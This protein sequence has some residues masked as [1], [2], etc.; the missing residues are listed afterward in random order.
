VEVELEES[1]AGPART[2]R[3]EGR[4]LDACDEAGAPVCFSCR[5]GDCGTCRVEVLAG[6]DR[7]SPPSADEAET[8]RRLGAA[9][10]DRLACQV[11]VRR[12]PGL[13]RLRWRGT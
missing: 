1:A 4:L 5:G 13:V 8:L 11:R 3:A 12:G 10:E 6:A 9:P 7:L 2:L